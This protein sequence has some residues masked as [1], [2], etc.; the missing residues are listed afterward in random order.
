VLDWL[1]VLP[2]SQD[3]KTFNRIGD[4]IKLIESES[5]MARL[6]DPEIEAKSIAIDGMSRDEMQLLLGSLQSK[7]IAPAD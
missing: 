2:E 1:Y 5:A 6:Y 7:Q 4:C 3:E